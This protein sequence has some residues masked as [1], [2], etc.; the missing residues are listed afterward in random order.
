[1]QRETQTILTLKP[2]Q[3]LNFH[4]YH[5]LTSTL[6]WKTNPSQPSQRE[7]GASFLGAW[8]TR[9][10]QPRIRVFSAH[11]WPGWFPALWCSPRSHPRSLGLAE[12]EQP[13]FPRQEAASSVRVP[14]FHGIS[15]R[16]APGCRCCPSLR[17]ET[18]PGVVQPRHRIPCQQTG[19][20][21][22]NQPWQK[23]FAPTNSQ[24]RKPPDELLSRRRALAMLEAVPGS[25][26]QSQRNR[27]RG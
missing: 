13:P 19:S 12:K 26:R 6:D 18:H 22:Q 10:P 3:L 24:F 11:D 14:G 20:P 9:M 23:A 25:Q 17:H 4:I 8:L 1:M 2:T 5:S 21:Q 27:H 7:Q 16:R 15:S